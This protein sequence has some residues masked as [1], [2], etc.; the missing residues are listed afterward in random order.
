MHAGKV[1]LASKVSFYVRKK[2]FALFMATM[3]PT[4][5]TTILDL[6]VT[7]DNRHQESNYFER[8]YP[9]TDKVACAGIEDGSHLEQEYPGVVF[10]PIKA[11]QPLPF[12]NQQFDIVFSNA[13]IE[14]TGGERE[15][16][17]F[18]KEI[19]RVSKAFFITTPNRWFPVEMHTVLP[20]LHYLPMRI[21]RFVLA[22]IGL[23]YWASEENLNLLDAR[24]FSRLFPSS[25]S[26]KV[27]TVT[28]LGIPSNLIA[29]GESRAR[30]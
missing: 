29:Y 5:E 6:G 15:Q 20:F 16:Q 1:P 18:I 13:V 17:F 9:Y 24:G 25:V 26:V 8:F 22:R 19:L 7:S 30:E 2:M 14:H 10:V 27:V 23:R 12:S 28:L 21:Y 3:R 11:N 4:G